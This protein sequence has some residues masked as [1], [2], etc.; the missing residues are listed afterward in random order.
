MSEHKINLS[1]NK[2]SQSFG[3]EDYN[4]DHQWDFGEGLVIN[5]SSA[6]EFLGNPQYADPERAFAASISSCHML[7][8]IAICSKKKI[9]VEQYDDNATAFLEKNEQG[10]MA[11]TRVVLKPRVI[12][13]ADIEIDK[14]AIKKIHHQS[15]KRCFLA[16]SV[17]SKVIIEPVWE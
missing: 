2:Q 6:P 11:I 17:R 8:F 1:W 3:Y 7:F 5:A 15:H 16:N 9:V 10:I 12:F 13:A 4:R 14:E